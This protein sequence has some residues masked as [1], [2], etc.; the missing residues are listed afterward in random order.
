MDAATN[1]F[2][3]QFAGHYKEASKKMGR[4]NL[5]IFGKTGVGKSTLINVVFGDNVAKTGIGEPVTQDEC[6]Y[7]HKSGSFGL[8][9]TRGL[10]IGADTETIIEDSRSS[11]RGVPGRW[12]SR[13]I[14]VVLR[15]RE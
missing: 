10:E 13:F 12:R 9:D 4:F 15:T 1:P 14:C 7:F 5:A 2:A 11:S 6:L 8:L 3:G